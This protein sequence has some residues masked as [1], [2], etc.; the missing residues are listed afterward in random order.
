MRLTKQH[1]ET[2]KRIAAAMKHRDE[3]LAEALMR[4]FPREL[5]GEIREVLYEML[6]ERVQNDRS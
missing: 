4:T 1:L 5:T 6:T 2:V 3:V